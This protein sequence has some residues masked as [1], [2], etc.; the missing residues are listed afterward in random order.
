M[1]KSDF[2][3]P[4][5]SRRA[6]IAS[7]VNTPMLRSNEVQ[8]DTSTI[9][10]QLKPNEENILDQDNDNEHDIL[11]QYEESPCTRLSLHFVI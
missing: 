5:I 6:T 1:S 8:R 9:S 3:K 11:I 2:F 4:P 7:D 10:L